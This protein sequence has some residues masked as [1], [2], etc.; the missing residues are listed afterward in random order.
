M[1]V[2]AGDVDLA[3]ILLDLLIVVVAAKVAAEVAERVRLPAVVGE[4]VAGVAIGPSGFGL[5]RLD[6]D[7]STA[8]A[9]LA[10]LGVLLLLVG[11]G[12]EMDLAELG[13]VGRQAMAVAVTGVIVPFAAGTAVGV[14][15]FDDVAVAV[16][17]GAALDGHQRGD[18]GAG[19]R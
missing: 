9:L 11:V 8:L 10:E 13:R 12:L 16:F 17:V 2:A 1:I 5:I 7:R 14:A 6:G 18:H 3:R 15:M 4:I 19:V